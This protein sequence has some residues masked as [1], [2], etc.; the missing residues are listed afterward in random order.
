MEVMFVLLGSKKEE[1]P[2]NKAGR[3]GAAGG[4]QV[5]TLADRLTSLVRLSGASSVCLF[6]CCCR[7]VEEFGLKHL[8]LILNGRTLNFGE[9]R[10]LPVSGPRILNKQLNSFCITSDQ[11]LDQ[12]GV[13]NHSKVMVLRVS[14][15]Q[16]VSK[17]EEDKKNQSESIQRTQKGFQIL[18]ERGLTTNLRPTEKL[19]GFYCENLPYFQ[20]AVKIQR[21]LHSWRSQTRRGTR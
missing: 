13:K 19:Q 10:P 20:M 12:Q 15:S 6:F 14:D 5:S 17:E 4:G 1:L 16:Q 18:S 7:I 21:A 11:H 9:S 2:G 8:K 3:D